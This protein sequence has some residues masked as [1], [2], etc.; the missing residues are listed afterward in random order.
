MSELNTKKCPKC[1]A[2]WINNQHYWSGTNKLGN[3][4]E[5]AS[6]ICDNPR[7]GGNACI[8]PAK[9]T[10]KGTGWSQRLSSMDAIDSEHDLNWG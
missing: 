6:L 7:L 5:L 10:T 3:E 9:G 2:T 8:N 4:A 1:G